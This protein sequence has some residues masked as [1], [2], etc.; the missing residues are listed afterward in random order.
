[1][2]DVNGRK[3]KR[4]DEG[5]AK[6]KKKA[7]IDP[8]VPSTPIRVSSVKRAENCPPVIGKGVTVCQINH[9]CV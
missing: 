4:A 9:G 1:M 7:A 8:E 6:P 5:K 3:R 2:A